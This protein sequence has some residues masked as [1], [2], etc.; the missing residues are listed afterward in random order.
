MVAGVRAY[1]DQALRHSL[2]YSHEV[3]QADEALRGGGGGGSA[4]AAAADRPAGGWVVSR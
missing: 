2:L 3:Q 4:A 1:F